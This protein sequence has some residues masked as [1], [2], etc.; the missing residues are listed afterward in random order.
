MQFLKYY[1]LSIMC[2][3]DVLSGQLVFEQPP[4]NFNPKIEIVDCFMTFN[5]NVL[6]LKRQ[7]H[8]SEGNKWGVPGGKVE[9]G[10]TADQ[11]V[12]REVREETGI[13]LAGTPLKY[14]GK[15]Y[16]RYLEIDFLYH[17]V[18]T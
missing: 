7:P 13:D 15:V 16:V 9:K 18:W 5:E 10:E 17:I 14:F 11:A 6:F 1:F 12:L 4:E 8:K 2:F 3:M